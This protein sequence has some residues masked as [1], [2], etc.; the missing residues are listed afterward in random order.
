[1]DGDQQASKNQLADK[2]DQARF[3]KAMANPWRL[4]ILAE[5]CDG[6]L[7]VG[8]LEE[9]LGLGQAYV[10]QQLAR[11]RSEGLVAGEREGRLVNYSL[12]DARVMHVLACLDRH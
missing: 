5:L 1:M 12:V 4:R 3:L 11:L 8:E 9:R 10:S 7:S 2:N 6:A